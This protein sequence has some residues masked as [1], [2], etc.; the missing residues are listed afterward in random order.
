MCIVTLFLGKNTI[1]LA[2]V[3]AGLNFDG[4]FLK[5]FCSIARSACQLCL[6]WAGRQHHQI[7]KHFPIC[8]VTEASSECGTLGGT[9][10][11]GLFDFPDYVSCKTK[12]AGLLE[13]CCVVSASF[14]HPGPGHHH[15]KC[16]YLVVEAA[17]KHSCHGQPDLHWGKLAEGHMAVRATWPSSLFT[18]FRIFS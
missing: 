13:T 10:A 17:V 3:C 9:R 7:S 6:A 11:Q 15:W 8:P 2:P 5:V 4:S 16:L 18:L 12:S 14:I 1:S